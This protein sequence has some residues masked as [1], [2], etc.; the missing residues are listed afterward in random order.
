MHGS[1]GGEG[2]N[3]SRPLSLYKNQH[4]EKG[5]GSWLRLVYAQIRGEFE[6]ILQFQ[7]NCPCIFCNSCFLLLTIHY[8]LLVKFCSA[9]T[10]ILR[11]D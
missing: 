5:I 1:E 9:S 7:K 8:S 11:R 4:H 6:L 3:P 2:S 10:R